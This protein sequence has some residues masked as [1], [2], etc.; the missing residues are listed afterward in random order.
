MKRFA[1][2]PLLFVL[3]CQESPVNPS[4]TSVTPETTF[5]RSAPCELVDFFPGEDAVTHFEGTRWVWDITCDFHTTPCAADVSVNVAFVYPDGRR[6]P[7]GH[8]DAPE[9][10]VNDI[11]V[12]HVFTIEWV[13]PKEW[14]TF[15][16]PWYPEMQVDVRAGGKRVGEFTLLLH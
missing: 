10:D 7:A 16:E 12:R 6:K 15:E 11:G 5:K 3:A 14:A 13:A 9:V 4:E 1:L 8:A 2:L